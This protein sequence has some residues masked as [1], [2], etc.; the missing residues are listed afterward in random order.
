MV[1][2]VCKCRRLPPV[3]EKRVGGEGEQECVSGG[4]E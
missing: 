1:F 2:Q 4:A 3:F